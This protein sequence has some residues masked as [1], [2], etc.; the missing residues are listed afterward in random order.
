MLLNTMIAKP[1]EIVY[2]NNGEIYKNPTDI[3][4]DENYIYDPKSDPI[5]PFVKVDGKR[6][7]FTEQF[8]QFFPVF[9]SPVTDL[10]GINLCPSVTLWLYLGAETLD[11]RQNFDLGFAVDSA[12]QLQ[13]IAEYY[14]LPYPITSEIST[15]IDTK[16]E[17]ICLWNI[18]RPIVL[19]AVKFIAGLPAILK[20]Y[21]FPK[22]HE[23]WTVWMYGISYYDHGKC[24]EAGAIYNKFTGGIDI[25]GAEMRGQMGFR[26]AE[27]IESN[28]EDGV[29]T[30]YS[31]VDKVDPGMF[32]QG[33][34]LDS[35]GNVLRI[36]HY[37]STRAVRIMIG[38]LKAGPTLSDRDLCPAVKFWVGRSWYDN[39][40]EEELLFA[41]T[42][43]SAML[44]AVAEYYN[45]P[46]PYNQEQKIILDTKPEL[47]RARH[48]D[49]LNLGEGKMIPGVI[50]SVIIKDNKPD[51]LL[52]Y[53]FLRQ[54]EF[55]NQ[56]ELPIESTFV[57]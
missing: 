23:S 2:V 28:R 42:G 46:V 27:I 20:L 6:Y 4:L 51:R 31:F 17:N 32:W 36:K 8:K 16:P 53:T 14:N 30:R 21:T 25:A 48:Y 13:Q 22:P 33:N 3:I 18:G 7:F 49:F 50:A 12:E 35:N 19:G 37:E 41:V 39:S 40:T 57:L 5:F 54:W 34:E 15:L 10:T 29:R 38:K 1:K 24:Y 9:E 44:D 43:G 47:Y 52:L 55:E 26:K 56:I 11:E 45:L